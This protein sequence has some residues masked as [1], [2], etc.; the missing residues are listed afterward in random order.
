MSRPPEGTPGR[1]PRSPRS[2][3]FSWQGGDPKTASS[4]GATL[5]DGNRKLLFAGTDQTYTKARG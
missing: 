2:H 5:T 1:P 4:W 3:R